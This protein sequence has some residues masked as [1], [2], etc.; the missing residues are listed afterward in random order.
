MA[1]IDLDEM[2]RKITAAH[3]M[4]EALCNGSARWVMHVPARPDAD[5]D[6]VIS[7]GL[8]AGEAALRELRNRR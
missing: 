6:L 1:E 3:R 2:A 7:D 4:V 5:P 8:M